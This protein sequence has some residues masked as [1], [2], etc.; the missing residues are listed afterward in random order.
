MMRR[1][2][3]RAI[4]NPDLFPP[5]GPRRLGMLGNQRLFERGITPPWVWSATKCQEYWATATEGTTN[6][7]PSSYATKNRAIVGVLKDFW[8]PEVTPESSV[9]EVGCNAGANLKGLHDHGYRDLAALEINPSAIDEM[10]RGFPELDPTVTIGPVEQ[11]LPTLADDS[12]DV[13]FSM[14]V[15]LHIHPSSVQVFQEMVRVARRYVCVIE[16]ES[17]T[18]P[19]IFARNYQRIFEQAACTQ[20]RSKVLTEAEF[21]AVGRDYWGYTARLFSVPAKG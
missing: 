15:L 3:A 12:V 16:A 13:V 9:L 6:N 10:R 7:E 14:A 5:R 4:Y 2:A 8:Q 21:P 18:L 17:S 1:L 11:T 20:L 19:Y